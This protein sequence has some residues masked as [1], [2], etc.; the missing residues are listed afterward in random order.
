VLGRNRARQ[1]TPGDGCRKAPQADGYAVNPTP[2]EVYGM[3]TKRAPL[4]EHGKSSTYRAGCRCQKCR[5]A[6][7]ARLR[8]YQARLREAKT[9]PKTSAKPNKSW[10]I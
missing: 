2:S 4:G 3:A 10:R 6:Q 8:A 9:N 7:A 5:A 1:G